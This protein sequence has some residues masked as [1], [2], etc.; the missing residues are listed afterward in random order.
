MY[1]FYILFFLVCSATWS[2]AQLNFKTQYVDNQ[3]GHMALDYANITLFSPDGRFLYVGAAEDGAI[4]V[5]SFDENTGEI[6]LVQIYTNDMNEMEV[7]AISPDGRFLYTVCSRNF[8]KGEFFFREVVVFERD[9]DNGKIKMVDTYHTGKDGV[10]GM[11][12]IQ[13]IVFSPDGQYV[14]IF[15]SEF[16]RNDTYDPPHVFVF[17]RDMNTG[18]LY[19]NNVYTKEST[20]M[21]WITHVSSALIPPSGKHMYIVSNDANGD[22]ADS[23]F[24]IMDI[25]PN[26][27]NLSNPQPISGLLASYAFLSHDGQQIYIEDAYDKVQHYA[28]DDNAGQISLMGTYDLPEGYSC[29]VS[30]DGKFIYRTN[31]FD[32]D[33]EIISINRDANGG[34]SLAEVHKGNDGNTGAVKASSV[35]VSPNSRWVIV[36]SS[37]KSTLSVYEQGGAVTHTNYASNQ[38]NPVVNNNDNQNTNPDNYGY[39][40]VTTITIPAGELGNINPSDFNS[41]E[42]LMQ[43]LERL[44]I[45]TDINMDDFFNNDAFNDDVFNDDFFDDNKNTS[46]TT[47]KSGG[48][49]AVS[50]VSSSD[51]SNMKSQIE[52]E[53]SSFDQMDKA[54]E[55]VKGRCLSAAQVAEITKIFK[56]DSSKLEFAKFAA[57]YTF[58]LQNYE[59]VVN[60]LKFS[61]SKDELREHVN[62]L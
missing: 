12:W 35:S 20:G 60:L 58:D 29:V 14:Y 9:L 13:N 55:L 2:T 27:G 61:S 39:N 22:G 23:R 50:D 15:S 6:Q 59:Q 17:S 28:I 7:A 42:E 11:R 19:L 43:E 3:G 44:G 32:N 25:D 41:A 45:E 56:M 36:S 18:R 8:D 4:S 26:T 24:L 54:E 62:S 38:N 48:N 30:A 49:C 16:S 46:N 47:T 51:L 5:Y 1:R 10:T 31:P 34:L 40:N 33:G 57:E 52:G 37:P 21:H 53:F